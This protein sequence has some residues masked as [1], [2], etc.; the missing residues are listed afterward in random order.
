MAWVGVVT[1]AG[2]AAIERSIADSEVLNLNAVKVGTG[3]IPEADMM[4]A[5]SVT[6]YVGDGSITEKKYI[7]DG[8]KVGAT[9]TPFASPYKIKQVG[10]FGTI[11]NTTVLVALYQNEDG[12]DIPSTSEFPDFCYT[13]Y[14]VWDVENSDN[15]TVTID[16]STTVTV[17]LLT[18]EMAKKVNVA[19]GAT[20]SGKYMKVDINGDVVPVEEVDKVA[21]NQGSENAGKFMIVGDDGN[22]VP[23]EVPF[24]E[25][26]DY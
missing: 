19:Q 14:G 18:T 20:N 21:L 24:A 16:P 26:E 7:N 11:D 6:N 5:T 25:G 1:T 4:S 22:V 9:I 8:L 12:I 15:I 2:I 10:V 3:T 13:L 17:A 23:V